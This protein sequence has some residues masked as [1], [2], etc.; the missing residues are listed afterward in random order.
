MSSDSDSRS[1]LVRL[2]REAGIFG[3]RDDALEDKFISG[4]ANPHL[5]DIGVDSLSEMEL[6]IGIENHWGVSITPVELEK[7][8]TLDSLLERINHLRGSKN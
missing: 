4:D 2:I 8:A 5:A 1:V 3:L 6:C 7:L